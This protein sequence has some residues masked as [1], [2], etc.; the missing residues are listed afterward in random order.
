[1]KSSDATPAKRSA[2][3]SDA[4]MVRNS[5]ARKVKAGGR[6]I[7]G[8]VLRPEAAEALAK[9]EKDGF[10]PSATACIEQALIETAKRRKL[11]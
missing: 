1:M 7:P 5:E 3:L 11:V 9:L 8:G 6:R 2:T 4:E 10:A